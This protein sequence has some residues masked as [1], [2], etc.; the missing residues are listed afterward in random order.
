M[1]IYRSIVVICLAVILF[2]WP[3]MW[4]LFAFWFFF[5]IIGVWAKKKDASLGGN[6]VYR[7]GFGGPIGALESWLGVW[8]G[9]Y[10]WKDLDHDF[11]RR[12]RE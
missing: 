2:V 12:N 3:G 4:V 10:V 11:H 6:S 1:A 8:N 5:A 7:T 9:F